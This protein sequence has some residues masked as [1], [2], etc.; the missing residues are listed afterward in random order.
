MLKIGPLALVIIII[1][2]Y[3][4]FVGNII[5][6]FWPI[7]IKEQ[8]M[9]KY[10][11]LF[12]FLAFAVA[13]HAQGA[14]VPVEKAVVTGGKAALP[15]V[16]S[17]AVGSAAGMAATKTVVKNLT[18]DAGKVVAGSAPATSAAV[19]K[20]AVSAAG[21][22]S[23]GAAL[24][25]TP[26]VGG[27]GAVNGLPIYE[28]IQ[29]TLNSLTTAMNSAQLAPLVKKGVFG[30]AKTYVKFARIQAVQANGGE[31][32][33]TVLADGTVETSNVANAGDWIVTNPGGEQ[34]IV[35]ADKFAKKYEAA[36]DLG[37]GWFK[38]KG[39]PQ[40]FVQ[41]P[42]DMKVMASWGEEQTL[43]KGAYLNVTNPEDIYGVAE[44]EFHDTYKLLFSADSALTSSEIA[45]LVEGGLFGEPQTYVKFARIQAVQ[46]DGGEAIETVLA[47][48][49]VETSNVANAGDWIVTNPGGEQYIVP[50]DKFAK[51]YEA[52][53][54][55]GAGWFKPKGGPQQFVQISEDMYVMASWGE[56]QF[57]KKGAY[58]NVTN[59]GD[60]YGVAEAE[61]HETYKLASAL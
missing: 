26:A 36:T 12:G 54:D 8:A 23:A 55:L 53:T 19:G 49:T 59:L 25:K 30:N 22:G 14:L 45:P 56:K 10:T 21:A 17:T 15:A 32:I 5:W 60:I 29:T 16:G 40:K 50:A 48:G 1:I 27:M 28:N 24:L 11:L 31:A 2:V 58:L 52:A 41:I 35:P 37:A 34:Y 61:F 39:G 33:E 57:L 47:D 46:A 18:S 6:A 51:K 38:P 43:K 9:K 20:T 3:T 4:A 7:A 13:A 42:R 44:A